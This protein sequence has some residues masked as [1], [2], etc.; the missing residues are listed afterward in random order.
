MTDITDKIKKACSH[1]SDCRKIYFQNKIVQ[2]L[3]G[4]NLEGAF[5]LQKHPQTPAKCA[6]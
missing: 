2:K 5:H 1:A 6:F 4:K 3:R